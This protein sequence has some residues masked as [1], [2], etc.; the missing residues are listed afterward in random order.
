MIIDSLAWMS[1]NTFDGYL[2]FVSLSLPNLIIHLLFMVQLTQLLH[3][4]SYLSISHAWK[5]K[6]RRDILP[7]LGRLSNRVKQVWP[8]EKSLIQINRQS[9]IIS[10]NC[11]MKQLSF[12][13]M[14]HTNCTAYKY[15]Q[16]YEVR[17]M[18][19]I[20]SHWLTLCHSTV[21]TCLYAS[22]SLLGPR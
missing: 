15:T 22:W 13:K 2:F 4:K 8:S 7:A 5:K 6:R 3:K 20:R 9:V 18:C 16:V 11:R 1:P 14:S 21:V 17:C 10:L 12:D 19:D